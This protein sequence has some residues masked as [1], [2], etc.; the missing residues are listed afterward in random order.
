MGG[1]SVSVGMCSS[2]WATLAPVGPGV[3]EKQEAGRRGSVVQLTPPGRVEHSSRVV[4]RRDAR[5]LA[6]V[7][8]EMRLVVVAAVERQ[9][10]EVRAART[11]KLFLGALEPQNARHALR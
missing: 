6:E 8:V 4:G 5:Q 2:F 10:R 11:G 1:V 7:P 9:L 3:L